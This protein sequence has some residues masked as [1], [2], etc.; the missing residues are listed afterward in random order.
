MTTPAHPPHQTSI[1]VRYSPDADPT[2]GSTESY[3]LL[4][5]SPE[6]MVEID[7]ADAAGHDVK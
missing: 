2:T 6:L 1:V 7:R 5:I 3:K 4:E